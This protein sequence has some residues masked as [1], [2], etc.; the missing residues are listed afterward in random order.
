MPPSITSG[1]FVSLKQFNRPFLKWAGNKT[2]VLPSLLPLLNSPRKQFVEPFSG[3]AAAF[4]NL[5]FEEYLI[6]DVNHDLINLFK[7]VKDEGNAFVEH[8]KRLFSKRHN[9]AAAFYRLRNEFN[10]MPLN[11]EKAAV[12]LYLNR[13]GYNGLCRYNAKGEFNVPFGKYASPY[14]PEKELLTF[15]EK[16]QRAI[17]K[18]QP[19]ESTFQEASENSVIYADPPYIPLPDTPSFTSYAQSEFGRDQHISL[20]RCAKLAREQGAYVVISNHDAPMAREIYSGGRILEPFEVRRTI[21]CNGAQR[22]MAPEIFITYGARLPRP[23]TA[24]T[25]RRAAHI[26]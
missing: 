23:A 5:E 15:H 25:A 6:C 17:F 14:F 4:L 7:T 13:H 12:F 10:E 26:R 1:Y 16:A 8:A 11:T 19:F 22:V 18:A 9:T 2:R 21:S 20:S 24:A 3:S